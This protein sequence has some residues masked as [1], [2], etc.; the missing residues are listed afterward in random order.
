MALGIYSN[1]S[2]ERRDDLTKEESPQW[3]QKI[4]GGIP[5]S[6]PSHPDATEAT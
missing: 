4:F 3:I 1:T 5:Q 2:S 6:E